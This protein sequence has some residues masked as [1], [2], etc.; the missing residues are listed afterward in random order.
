[1]LLVNTE[2]VN[3]WRNGRQ[4]KSVVHVVCENYYSFQ[5]QML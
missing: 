1:M 3:K 5:Q 2:L 4:K